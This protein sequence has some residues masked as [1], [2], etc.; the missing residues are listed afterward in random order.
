MPR[1][2]RAWARAHP[3]VMRPSPATTVDLQQLVREKRFYERGSYVM[4]DSKK[5]GVAVR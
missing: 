5:I 3:H 4:D 1:E 2:A